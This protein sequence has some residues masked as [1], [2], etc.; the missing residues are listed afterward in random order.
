MAFLRRIPRLVRTIAVRHRIA[1]RIR[2]PKDRARDVGDRR[3]R[4]GVTVPPAPPDH[5]QNGGVHSSSSADD[6]PAPQP[7]VPL[8]DTVDKGVNT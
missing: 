8:A 7:G 1:T 5:L 4:Y 2:E 3:L 6:M